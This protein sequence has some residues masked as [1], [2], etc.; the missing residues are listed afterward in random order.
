MASSTHIHMKVQA[1][2]KRT[3]QNTAAKNQVDG[4]EKDGP[5]LPAISF[6]E[7]RPD[8]HHRDSR[9]LFFPSSIMK[10]GTFGSGAIRPRGILRMVSSSC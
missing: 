3:I 5:G 9:R 6:T 4:V 1:D 8:T 10:I 7:N 2:N